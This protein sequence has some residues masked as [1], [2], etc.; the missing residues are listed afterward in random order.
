MTEV[1]SGTVWLKRSRIELH[2]AETGKIELLKPLKFFPVAELLTQDLKG[3][4]FVEKLISIQLI[5]P[6]LTPDVIQTWPDEFL[7]KAILVW[8]DEVGFEDTSLIGP[9]PFD[10]FRDQTAI[11]IRET[12]SKLVDTFVGPMQDIVQDFVQQVLAAQTVLAEAFENLS[13]AVRDAFKPVVDHINDEFS[14]MGGPF[15]ESLPVVT[16]IAESIERAASGAETITLGGYS[17]V[18]HD[19]TVRYVASFSDY[20]HVPSRVRGAV[21]TNKLLAVTRSSSFIEDMRVIFTTSPLLR[22]RW[23][24]VQLAWK[25]HFRREYALAIPALFAQ[26]EGVFGDL[27]IIRGR[28]VRRGGEMFIRTK[29]DRWAKVSGLQNLVEYSKLKRE[30]LFIEAID[31]ML[32]QLIPDR[33]AIL[34]GGNTKYGRAK[35]SV[36][37][38]FLLF[39]L[40]HVVIDLEQGN[41]SLPA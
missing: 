21:V 29:K 31:F 19:L 27:L 23:H 25:A 40:S 7:K 22:R 13:N 18:L 33:N 5:T 14:R 24:I 11:F 35:L 2:S 10:K 1:T 3:R 26:I 32:N 9:I 38:V 8:S 6:K 12:S 15:F 39:F 30:P 4:E 41:I 17:F 36:Q 34:H 16:E 37:L 28:G 20:L